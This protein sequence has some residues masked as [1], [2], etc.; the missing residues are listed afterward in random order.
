[1][2]RKIDL[3][4]LFNEPASSFSNGK[5]VPNLKPSIHS[6]PYR[7]AIVGEAPGLDELDQGK[8]FVGY[9]G[10][11]LDRFLSRFQV[12][13]DACFIGNICQTRPEG[14]KIATFNWDGPEITL[15]LAKLREDLKEFK[16]NIMLL[17][18]G[19]ALHAFKNPNVIPKKRKTKDGHVFVFPDSIGDWRG[20][21]F[22]SHLDAP[23]PGVKCISSY[24]PAFCLRQYDY[25]PMLMMDTKRAIDE[26]LRPE[27][28]LPQR[29]LLVN[30]S[31]EELLA[32]CD[33]VL[34]T[35]GTIGTDI[36]GYYNNWKCISFASSPSYSFTVPFVDMSGKSLWTV[37]QETVL[38][39]KVVAILSHPQITKV[40][41]NGLYDRFVTQYG[42]NLVVRGPSHDIMLRHW[43]LYCELEKS[44]GVQCSIY[45]KEP[46][47]KSDIKSDDR[48]TFWAYCAR[49]SAVTKEIDEKLDKFLNK[50][51]SRH[52][53]F[54]ITLLNALLY[55]ELRGIRYD[56]KLA[57]ERLEEVTKAIY[58]LQYHLDQI[59][60]FGIKTSDKALLRSIVREVLCYK[61]DAS[62]VKK[63][64]EDNYE[65]C[66]NTLS[67]EGDLDKV[68]MGRL[69][70]VLGKELNTKG[71]DLK[72]YLYETLKLPV[73]RDPLTNA[74]TSDYEALITL[75]KK[76]SHPALPLILE[77]T[78]LR[79]RA[80]MLGIKTDPDG[81]IR[82]SYN[83]VGSETGR[84]TSLTSPTGS[85]YNLQTIPDENTLKP[86]GHPLRIGMRDL[87]M[88]DEG[89][90]IA[91]CDLK[92]AD[93]WTV[94]ANLTSLG[95]P[96]ML[97]D[98]KAGLK[99]ASILCFARRHG[100]AAV[101]G[102]SRDVL[103]E[104]CSE[105][106]KD[107]WDYFAAKQVVWGFCY[108]MGARK[109]SQHVFNVSEGT[110]SPTESEMEVMKQVLIRRYTVPLWWKATERR[111]FNQ[112]Y[113]PKL[114]S[115]SGHT[116]MFFGRKVD[117]VGQALAHEPQS[118]TTYATN[119]AMYRCWTDREN[120]TQ[121]I[122]ENNPGNTVNLRGMGMD[123][124][125][126]GKVR[127]KTVLRIEPLHQVHDEVV[128]QFR[129]SDVAWAIA[130]VKSWFDN[131]ITIAG[132]RI[133]IPFEGAY[134]TNWAMD[135]KSKVGTI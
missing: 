123:T 56:K 118:V 43:E 15:G 42:Y 18:G 96:T 90:Y 86:I 46:Y 25:T 59:A 94:G 133:T 9:S 132:I 35:K 71:A 31:F 44:L 95:D 117:I 74:I 101:S 53:Q 20:S 130:K 73:Q 126:M 88:A 8:P 57:K 79:T 77:I 128:F 55:M 65:W 102:K 100:V 24:H 91:K 80:Q 68:A 47:Y 121:H 32:E 34:A 36:E 4:E 48:V 114:T 28:E 112:P 81:R 131:E 39:K 37:D 72:K 58:S 119:Q 63:G 129:Q 3:D 85:G 135:E 113:P 12:L 70:I 103:K 108:L 97:E 29:Q 17:L 122:R 134:G 41:Q 107:D 16:P 33:K 60:G 76:S 61:R 2:P 105:V 104:L 125:G 84:V 67:C 98:L 51:S 93:G 52:Y 21:F 66:I 110:V 40:W 111:L 1:M 22:L 6:V 82:S 78:E 7:L 69:S 5:T 30:L 10:Q 106:K 87:A 127:Y 11:L 99:P 116:R 49:D 19:S 120:R 89:C 92:G 23:L 54:N 75:R 14:N 109:A 50:E 64:C 83:E 38:T 27:L 62:Q 45:L 124:S 115:P 26:A 13:R